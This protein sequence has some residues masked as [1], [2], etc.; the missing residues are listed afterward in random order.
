MSRINDLIK[1]LCPN[2]VVFKTVGDMCN[3][4]TGGETPTDLIK[5][6]VPRDDYIYP[7]YSNGIGSNALYGY[8]KTYRIKDD[9]DIQDFISSIVYHI[10]IKDI[11]DSYKEQGITYDD[12]IS[13][14]RCSER[15]ACSPKELMKKILLQY[16]SNTI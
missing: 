11:L 5:E 2:G 15:I 7:V 1:E 3:V 10:A 4:Y 9:I 6:K 12:S 13:I 14:C 8:A 16:D